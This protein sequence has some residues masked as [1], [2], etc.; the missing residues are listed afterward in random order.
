VVQDGETLIYIA[1]IHGVTLEAL[2]AANPGI[3]PPFLPIGHKLIIPLAGTDDPQDEL[4]LVTPVPVQLAPVLCYRTP[5]NG[6]WC[7]TAARGGAV[8]TIEG[9]AATIT[10]YD[11]LGDELARK[12]A[13]GPL[14]LLKAQEV[15]PLA[16]F[17]VPPAPDYSQVT[18]TL[19]TAFEY[20]DDDERY[21]DVDVRL[22]VV[23]ALPGATRWRLAGYVSFAAGE[24][25]TAERITVLVVGLSVNGD[26]VGFNVW[27][28]EGAVTAGERVVIELDLFSLGPPIASI[29]ILAEAQAPQ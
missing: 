24:I 7:L 2:L 18:A 26:I 17:F 25:G 15:M 16:A 23:E 1:Y 8:G 19:L 28:S 21:L 27:E 9:L 29:E 6:L 14:N 20:A 12:T 11:A 22:E 5:S 10:L 3:D 13:Y 4:P